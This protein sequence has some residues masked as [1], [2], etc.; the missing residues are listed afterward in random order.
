MSDAQV[1][2]SSGPTLRELASCGG[3]AAKAPPALVATLTDLVA[4]ATGDEVIAGLSPFDDAA[5]YRLDDSRALVATVDFFPPLLD[6]PS[7]YGR[8][9]AANAVS[10]IYA[11]GADVTFAL[12][13]SGFPSIVSDE[14]I[15]AVNRAAADV[16]RECGG[17][18]LGGHS[19]RCRE[20][21]FGLCV[22]GFVH[23]DRVWRKSG[24]EAGDVLV[25]SK[26]IGTGVL[27]SEHRSAGVATA[28]ESMSV[29]N[30]AAAAALQACEPG[31][32][33][34]TD[35]TGYGLLGHAAEI[36]ERSDVTLCIDADR[37]PLLAGSH[38][39]SSAGI[40]TSNDATL[41]RR[42]RGQ[43]PKALDPGLRRLLFDPQTSGGL[44]AAVSP[45][46]AD[47]LSADGFVRV[48]D[49]RQGLTA[50]VVVR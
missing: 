27:L 2:R 42:F 15:A 5:V 46:N 19:V 31:P 29:T 14:D 17:V 48:G 12:A 43:L 24:A 36:A 47:T 21:V 49:V 3:C 1:L 8:V 18:C 26:P 34:V 16:L 4:E 33:A 20:P 40:G 6:D 35:V 7:D 25:L 13:L 38:R 9:A 41:A 11:M 28:T 23:P 39:A 50:Q 10:D 45:E 37:V 30:R 44:L 22:V 32:S